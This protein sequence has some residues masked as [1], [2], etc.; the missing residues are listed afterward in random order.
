MDPSD[1]DPG[2]DKPRSIATAQV[3]LWLQFLYLICGGIAPLLFWIPTFVG[4]LPV[5]LFF[6]VLGVLGFGLGAAYL[7]RLIGERSA[8]ARTV[9]TVA[10]LLFGMGSALVVAVVPAALITA[11]PW[12]GLQIMTLVNLHSATANEWFTRE[13]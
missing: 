4:F 1:I 12:F 11:A 3:G 10:M 6:F 8:R 7:S 2:P 5:P 9:A 13:A